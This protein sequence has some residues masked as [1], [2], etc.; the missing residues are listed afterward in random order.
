M[1]VNQKGCL[2]A[3]P[4]WLGLIMFLMGGGATWTL[5]GAALCGLFAVAVLLVPTRKLPAVAQP[6]RITALPCSICGGTVFTTGRLLG[7]YFSGSK[8]SFLP[9]T[10]HLQARRCNQCGHV[11]LFTEN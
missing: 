3:F 4:V 11:D 8:S 1:N 5:A 7:G 9:D 2:V 6:G 10:H